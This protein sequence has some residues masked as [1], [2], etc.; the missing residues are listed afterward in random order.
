MIWNYLRKLYQT[1]LGKSLCLAKWTQSNIYLATG[2]T[3]SCHHPL[4]HS[5]PVN[6]IKDNP[7]ALHNTCFKIKQRQK[8]L[9]GKRP[10][11]CDYC[12]RV[13]DSGNLSDRITKSF[14]SWSRPFYNQ[15]IKQGANGG[16]PKY[17]EVS[18]DNTCNLKCS[19]CGPS[20]SSKWVEELK[21]FGPWPNHHQ[22]Y[23]S[24]LNREHNPYVE[25]FW[26]WWPSLYKKLH[27][28]RITGGEPLLSKHTYKVLDKLKESPNKKLTLGINTNLCVPDTIIDKFINEIKN[29]KV[30][31]LVIHT[32][33]DTHGKAA[34]YARHGF[35]Y[36]KWYNNCEKIKKELPNADIDIMVTY[37][38]FSVTRFSLFLNDVIKLKRTPWYKRNKI[39]VSIG[40]LRN[41]EQLSI[42]GLPNNYTSFIQE[43][44]KV[45]KENNFSKSEINQLERLLPLFNK[46]IGKDKLQTQFKM[47]VD[48]HDRRRGTD[49]LK[50]F[51]ELE[52]FYMSC[53]KI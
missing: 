41:P 33:C 11:E 43:Q 49:F 15:I 7:S 32:S 35:N 20:Y 16:A 40:Y 38:I 13:E 29:V 27:T 44:V 36:K 10:S 46:K 50:T 24:I 19:Y 17:L 42:W 48:E 18:F 1:K 52:Q 4:P 9:E 6:E 21:Q 5:I 37:N 28:F 25:A 8:M 22:G 23:D 26:K 45:M 34:E 14:T 12:W 2:K 51:P 53:E 47:F 3:H 39:K 31:K 30:R